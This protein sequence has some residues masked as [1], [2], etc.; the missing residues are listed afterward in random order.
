MFLALLLVCATHPTSPDAAVVSDAPAAPR[1][2]PTLMAALNEPETASDALDELV[3]R[4]ASEH[5]AEVALTSADVGAR[6]WAITGLV[7]LGDAEALP[8]IQHD[9]TNPELVRIWA[10][11]GR[12]QLADRDELEELRPLTQTWPELTRPLELREAQL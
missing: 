2:I 9:T 12:I 4:G 11:A 10:A 1:S 6:G 8:V 5:L 3:R 7:Q